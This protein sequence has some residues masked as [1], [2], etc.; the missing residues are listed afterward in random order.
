MKLM[1]STKAEKVFKNR[2]KANFPPEEPSQQT[3][4]DLRKIIKFFPAIKTVELKMSLNITMLSPIEI[5]LLLKNVLNKCLFRN[6]DNLT[7]FMNM[8]SEKEINFLDDVY[9][10]FAYLY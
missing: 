3:M 4:I 6:F 10:S 5:F 7:N 8:T 9:L 2:L 1:R